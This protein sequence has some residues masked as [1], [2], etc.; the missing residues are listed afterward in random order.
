MLGADI[1]FFR[2][3]QIDW[4][5]RENSCFCLIFFICLIL[6]MS[7]ADANT[8]MT[9]ASRPS[10]SRR[11]ESTD[12][13]TLNEL[14]EPKDE[15]GPK[16]QRFSPKYP[17]Y[18]PIPSCVSKWYEVFEDY[19]KP[20]WDAFGIELHKVSSLREYLYQN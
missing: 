5:L 17:L 9:S 14:S 13:R 4:S 7:E 16:R 1:D 19:K 3:R 18:R 10:G 2:P 12:K 20:G 6:E 8:T 15:T 11:R